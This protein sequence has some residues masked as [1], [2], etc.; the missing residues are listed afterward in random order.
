[1]SMIATIAPDE[2]KVEYSIRP[3]IGREFLSFDIEGWDDVKKICKNSDDNKCYF[4]KPINGE[5][6][7]AKISKR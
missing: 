6:V 4:A 2:I 3:D 7:T 5:A 1:M